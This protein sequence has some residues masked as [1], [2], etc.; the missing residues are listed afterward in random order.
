MS[1]SARVKQQLINRFRVKL[2]EGD[3]SLGASG[4]YAISVASFAAVGV[5]IGF[6]TAADSGFE[7]LGISWVSV[8][9]GLLMVMVVSPFWAGN[10]AVRRHRRRLSARRAQYGGM[11][12]LTDELF[13][14]GRIPQGLHATRRQSLDSF[15]G[16]TGPGDAERVAATWCR[17]VGGIL[18]LSGVVA[19]ASWMYLETWDWEEGEG[20]IR[21]AGV[22][23]SSLGIGLGIAFLVLDSGLTRRADA[24]A[25]DHTRHLHE[26]HADILLSARE[27]LQSSPQTPRE[28]AGR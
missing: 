14:L 17:I 24:A 5:V 16:G 10:A 1:W 12:D 20:P 9:L 22:T 2:E 28:K 19:L 4:W 13:A 6:I 25:A 15:L 21:V 11:R 23:T 18:L 27:A 3:D 26:G 8:G 7:W